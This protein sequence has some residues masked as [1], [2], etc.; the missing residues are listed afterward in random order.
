MPHLLC[1][2]CSTTGFRAAFSMHLLQKLVLS[3]SPSADNTDKDILM[4]LLAAAVPGLPQR[5]ALYTSC[6]VSSFA[7]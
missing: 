5:S 4:Q 2:W 6:S 1:I 7:V 3:M